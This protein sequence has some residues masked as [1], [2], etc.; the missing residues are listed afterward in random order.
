MNISHI[1]VL[2]DRECFLSIEDASL[3]L[4]FN[5]TFYGH[6]IAGIN[7]GI[8]K[9]EKQR[10]VSQLHSLGATTVL[11]KFDAPKWTVMTK[12]ERSKRLKKE[13]LH[14]I[15]MH[16]WANRPSDRGYYYTACDVSA[17]KYADDKF[18]LGDI[19]FKNLKEKYRV[20]FDLEDWQSIYTGIS[21]LGEFIYLNHDEE[22][23]IKLQEQAILGN[24]M[25]GN[26]V[27]EAMFYLPKGPNGSMNFSEVHQMV[28]WMR[29]CN[30][31]QQEIT[32]EILKMAAEGSDPWGEVAQGTSDLAVRSH[33]N[34]ALKDS[35]GRGDVP[36][37]LASYID[38]FLAPARIDWK[39]ELRKFT[40][41]M[42]DVVARTTMTKKSK[43]F[44]TY[45]ALK[46]KRTQRVA[47]IVDTSG[48]VSD[49]EFVAFFSE[50]SGILQDNCE[51]IFIH[52]D[53]AVDQIDIY[54]KRLPSDL[55]ITRH[56]GG[57]T[58]FG[59]ALEF[60][61]TQGKNQNRFP[62]IGK[63][64]GT[65]YMTDGYAPAPAPED[66][67]MGKVLWI[68]T[69]KPV[70]NMIKEGFKGKIIFLDLA[71]EEDTKSNVSGFY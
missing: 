21:T 64:D 56:G 10:Q 4:L 31:T 69:Q 30:A 66:Y 28:D 3:H 13:T 14:Y 18:S 43:R 70:E 20:D 9:N 37:G 58:A 63:V 42:G 54:K 47:I 25:T 8:S 67:P 65:I 16:P 33:I 39:H 6:I 49:E 40:S 23:V 57:G 19:N 52:A 50:L 15:F 38:A 32:E 26:Q 44:G 17:N 71:D 55:R 36:A 51:I 22:E 48:S 53:A 61:K 29:K 41:F 24:F 46:I 7:K 35:K 11:V 45:P 5:E 68:T 34:T 59:P 62:T 60:V 12:E 2:E 27:N 1:K